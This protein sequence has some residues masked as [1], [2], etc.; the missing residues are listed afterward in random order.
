MKQRTQRNMP[1][2][3]HR[4]AVF[5]VFVL[6]AEVALSAEGFH[7][8]AFA[9]SAPTAPH[10]VLASGTSKLVH[11]AHETFTSTSLR[12]TW[13]IPVPPNTNLNAFGTWY[14]E[15]D[16]RA[17]PPVYE[18]CENDYS[19]SAPAADWPSMEVIE[20]TSDTRPVSGQENR[21]PRPVQAIRRAAGWAMG[22]L[23]KLVATS[24]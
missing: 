24:F 8:P 1:T 7:S 19:F 12:M 2:S 5:G 13:S 15:R 6:L 9:N 18:D 10:S 23:P 17:G 11:N 21:R 16:P 3:F 20:E 22:D 14:E 4:S